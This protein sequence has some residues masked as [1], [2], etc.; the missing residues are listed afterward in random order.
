MIPWSGQQLR[1]TI[2]QPDIFRNEVGFKTLGIFPG[3]AVQDGRW[4]ALDG[5]CYTVSRQNF[6]L[7]HITVI[8]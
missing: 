7:S 3:A 6:L 2:E 5:N 4:R 1:Q 8:I